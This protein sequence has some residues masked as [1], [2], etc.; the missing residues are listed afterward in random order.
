[1][2]FDSEIVIAAA[3]TGLR[4]TDVPITYHPRLGPSKLRRWRDGLRPCAVHVLPGTFPTASW[5]LER[6]FA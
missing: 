4:A 5:Y 6:P 3:Q 2:E 1:M